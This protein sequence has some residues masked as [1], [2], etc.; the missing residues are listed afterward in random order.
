[1]SACYRTV[2][3][4]VAHEAAL[5][6]LVNSGAQLP[7]RLPTGGLKP[8]DDIVKQWNAAMPPARRGAALAI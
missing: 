5:T 6:G 1:L 7:D 3:S 2:K 4:R 8:A